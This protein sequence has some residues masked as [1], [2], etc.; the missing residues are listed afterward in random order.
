MS[1]TKGSTER[2][3]EFCDV[4][5]GAGLEYVDGSMPGIVRRRCGRGFTYVGPEGGTVTDRSLRD[6]IDGLVIPPAWTDVWICSDPRGHIQATGRDADGRK[7]Y[8]YHQ[9]W[10]AAQDR[11]KFLRMVP[12]GLSLPRV[13]RRVG[14]DLRREGIPLDKVAA[15]A[16][17]VL[18]TA[19]IR[20]GN[21]Q[22]AVTNHSFGL[23]TLRDR[24]LTDEGSLLT[25]EFEAKSGKDARVEIEEGVLVD[26]LRELDDVPGYRLFQYRD[27]S[28][29]KRNL[30]S[31][32]VNQYL[33]EAAA[34]EASAKDF[35]TGHARVAV[36]V[37]DSRS[38]RQDQNARNL[39]LE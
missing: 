15:A 18:D 26:V 21:D 3:D 14:R 20:V 29:A 28:N 19:A 36:G 31:S 10:R 39:T 12:F 7:Q 4:A 8:L 25:L 17:R 30:T 33:A 34:P 24:H 1:T 23:T 27:D 5:R 35:R 38:K 13:R 16:V 11:K 22:Y 37:D 6:R 32:D 2:T 9:E